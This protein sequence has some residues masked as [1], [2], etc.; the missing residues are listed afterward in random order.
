MGKFYTYYVKKNPTHPRIVKR[1]PKENTDI[2]FLRNS[3]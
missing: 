3:Y 1:V 2:F